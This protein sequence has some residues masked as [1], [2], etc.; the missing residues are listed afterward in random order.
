MATFTWPAGDEHGLVFRVGEMTR[1]QS[2]DVMR[3]L[4]VLALA[5]VTGTL[6]FEE[7]G[8]VFVLYSPFSITRDG[9]E[10]GQAFEGVI[11]DTQV[12]IKPPLTRAMIAELPFTLVDAWIEAAT[13]AN[14]WVQDILKKKVTVLKNATPSDSA[15]SS[16][17]NPNSLKMETTGN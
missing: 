10:L 13:A 7:I 3:E 5:K 2:F 15:P 14:T 11:G 12:S 17:P 4:N 1:K 8:D 9:A 6:L 16:E